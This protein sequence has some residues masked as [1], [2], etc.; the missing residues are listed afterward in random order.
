MMKNEAATALQSIKA[1]RAVVLAADAAVAAD[2]GRVVSDE[3][4]LESRGNRRIGDAMGGHRSSAPSPMR[5]GSGPAEMMRRSVTPALG[6]AG[7]AVGSPFGR[8]SLP[9]MHSPMHPGLESSGAVAVARHAYTATDPG[10]L[11][12]AAGDHLE[13]LGPAEDRW[14]FGRHL[15]TGAQGWFPSEYVLRRRISSTG[16]V[17]GLDP[18]PSVHSMAGMYGGRMSSGRG[19]PGA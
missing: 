15:G 16:S 9:S 2:P 19:T 13:L 12:F 10:Q 7:G 1:L 4:L 6:L 17:E 14:Q 11:S 3:H 18:A 5:R 8:P